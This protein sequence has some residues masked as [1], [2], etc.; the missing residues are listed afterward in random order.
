MITK[1]SLPSWRGNSLGARVVRGSFFTFLSY[2][3]A[4]GLRFVSNIILTRLLFPEAFGLMVLV[5]TVILALELF[6]DTGVNTSIIQNKRGFERG[7]LDTAWTFQ[8][9]RG[10]VLWALACLA[11]GPVA[12]FYGEPMLAQ[13][14]PVAALS[15]VAMGFMSTNLAT[16]NKKILLGR[17]TALDLGC[18]LLG[19]GLTIL[20]AAWWR[21]V[22]ALVIGMLLARFVKVLL[23][24]LVLEGGRNR[25]AWDWQVVRELFDFG[26]FIVVGSIAGFFVNVGDRAILGKFVSL[27]DL[28]VYNIGWLLASVPM[29]VSRV[30][31]RKILFPLYSSNPPTESASNRRKIAKVRSSMTAG[32]MGICLLLG[33]TGDWLVRTLYTPDYYLAGPVLVLV[34]VAS[35]PTMIFVAYGGLLLGAG[36]SRDFTTMVVITAVV[37]TTLLYFGVSTYGMLGAII[38]LSLSQL[39]VYPVTVFLVR[40]HGGWDPLHDGLFVFLGLIVA[41]VILWMHPEAVALVRAGAS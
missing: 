32:M 7:F 25:L 2:G 39:L 1:F 4:Q 40:R 37:Q 23:S 22:W 33:L 41:A 10:V 38:A 11:A 29:A 30:F 34:S 5:Q 21:S 13:L 3:G 20:F 28:A 9:V 31:G 18:Q 8:I 27:T 6:S 16:A 17:L 36:S 26:K 19:L 14:L 35:L 15:V 12:D 24:H